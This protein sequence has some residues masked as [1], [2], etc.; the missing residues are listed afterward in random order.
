MLIS[1]GQAADL[2]IALSEKQKAKMQE[3]MAEK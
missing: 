3:L 2:A 1:D